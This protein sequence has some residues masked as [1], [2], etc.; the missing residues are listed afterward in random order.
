MFRVLA[1]LLL[2]LAPG[3]AA[4]AD[5]IRVYNWNDYIAPQVLE[6]FTK[7]TGIAVEYRTFSTDEELDKALASGESIDV[8]VPSHDELPDLIAAGKLQPLDM[9]RLPNRKHLDKQLLSKLAAVD[10]QNRYA[11]PYLWGAVGLAINTPQAEAAF[12]GP[13]PHSW[14]LLFDPAQSAKLAACG[15]SVLDAPDELLYSLLSYQGRSF[16]NSSPGRIRRAGD[17]LQHLRP[18]LRYVNSERY[19]DDLNQGKLCMA[20]AWVG[21]ALGASDAGQP[22]QFVIPEEGS[23]LF[24]DNLVIPAS[25]RRA[26]LAHQFIDYLMRPEVAARNT[27]ETLYPSANADA[28]EFLDPAL[29]ELLARDLDAAKSRLFALVPLSD[30]LK[31]TRD[32]VWNRFRDGS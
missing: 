28:R 2:T 13:L 26:D 6:D 3:L 11:A 25:A 8:A 29:R 10:P 5:S 32:E 9:S 20:V 22:V 12:G 30:K 15:I 19:I 24:I 4:A 31:S 23:S 16:A 14:S 1:P 21:D 27:S 18:N 7:T 17:T